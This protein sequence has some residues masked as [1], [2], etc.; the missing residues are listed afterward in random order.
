L[1]FD[2]NPASKKVSV[3]RAEIPNRVH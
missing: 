3:S 2:L 1:P